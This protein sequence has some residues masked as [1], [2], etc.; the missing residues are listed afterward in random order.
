MESQSLKEIWILTFIAD[1]RGYGRDVENS[2]I[3]RTFLGMTYLS[4]HW[5]EQKE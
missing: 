5:T 3:E 2:Q 1:V 4:E